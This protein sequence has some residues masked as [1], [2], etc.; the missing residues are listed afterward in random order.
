MTIDIDEILMDCEEGMEKAVD[1]L[2]NELR[3]I[4][5]GRATPALVEYI[6]IDYFDSP[7]DLRQLA[8][9]TIPEP[10]QLL[11]KP[12]DASSV[13]QIAKAIQAAGLGLNPTS[14]GKQI[15]IILPPLSGDRRQQ[16]IG[17][18]KQVGEQ[19]RVS[20]RHARRDANKHVDKALKDKTLHLSEDNAEQTKEEVQNLVKQYES[21]VDEVVN[22]K[23][24][25]IQEI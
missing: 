23:A 21:K 24:K 18:T 4:R 17:Q 25:E 19:A 10:T 3:G 5:T 2:R 9:I 13:Q 11:I 12:Y 20:I 7:T 14:E 6:K 1:H 8:L 22:S 15:R 16:L